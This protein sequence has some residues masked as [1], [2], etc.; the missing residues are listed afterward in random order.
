[1]A[2]V[3]VWGP[4]KSSFNISRLRNSLRRD[5]RWVNGSWLTRKDTLR[6]DP[7]T[8]RLGK[9]VRCLRCGI[10][11]ICAGFETFLPIW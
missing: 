7:L 11:S 10:R 6:I 8:P 2:G 3:C 1:M 5:D 9:L 4:A